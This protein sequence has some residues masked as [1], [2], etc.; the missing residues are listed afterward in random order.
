M[1]CRH[2][3]APSST[4]VA[5]DGAKRRTTTWVHS[6]RATVL[7]S[8]IGLVLVP[9]GCATSTVDTVRFEGRAP[10]SHSAALVRREAR[11]ASEKSVLD[12]QQPAV[13]RAK[14]APLK[15]SLEQAVMLALQNNRELR[16]HQLGPVIAGA[17]EQV[18]RGMYNPELYG[19]VQFAGERASETARAT[20]ERFDVEGQ[21]TSSAIGV[22]QRL[23]SGTT[24]EAM[25]EH[26][27]DESDRTP[28]QQG[29][30]LGLSITQSLL[31][32]LRPKVNLAAV[33]QAEVET[34]ASLQQLRG[35]V[36]AVVAET[37]RTYWR[38]VLAREEIAIY[39]S[40]LD[41]ARRRRARK[42]R[43]AN[44]A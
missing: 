35:F 22:R 37:E 10:T 43:G 1:T 32:G 31:R 8:L 2:A 14:E 30:R 3:R 12:V 38:F 21:R 5:G 15:L 33:R 36:S 9:A 27:F 11:R 4:G 17:F 20:G 41:L 44:R 25:V 28:E 16:V 24:V 26:E 29:A 39:Q 42:W 23:A 40:S 19:Q 13:S 18:E 7:L 34:R 6:G